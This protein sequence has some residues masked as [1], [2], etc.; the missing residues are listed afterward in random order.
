MKSIENTEDEN[1]EDT[2][3][4]IVFATRRNL[5]LLAQSHTWFLD[6]AFK[7]SPTIFTQVIPNLFT[8]YLQLFTI[9]GYI[10]KPNQ[11]MNPEHMEAI[12]FPLLYVLLTSKKLG[13]EKW[14]LML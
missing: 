11:S 6:G 1:T 13:N 12:S 7:V 9:I 5:E 2:P 4:V 8:N 14:Y 3:R 10:N